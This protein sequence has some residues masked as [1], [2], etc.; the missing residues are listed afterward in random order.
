VY[1]KDWANISLETL[2]SRVIGGKDTILND[3]FFKSFATRTPEEQKY[4]FKL[5]QT[6]FNIEEGVKGQRNSK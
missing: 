6:G 5:I 3:P 4:L 1:G 2:S